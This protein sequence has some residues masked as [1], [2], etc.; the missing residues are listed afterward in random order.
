[1][2]AFE[3][4]CGGHSPE[5]ALRIGLTLD[6]CTFTICDRFDGTPLAMFGCGGEDTDEPY[7]WALASDLLVPRAGRDFI[8]H[9][10]EW[11]KA[12]LKAVGG[13]ACNFVHAENTDATRWLLYCGAEFSPEIVLK[14]NQPFLK[15]TIT[16]KES[17]P[18]VPLL[19]EFTD[20]PDGFI[21]KIESCLVEYAPAECPLV[22]RFT[23][24]MYIRE[25]F[26]PKGTLL[27][28]MKHKTEHPFVISKGEIAVISDNENKVIY[29]APFTGITKPHTRRV[30][31]A[32]ED[33]IW[34]T[35]HVTDKTDVEEI[36]K[37]I[38]EDHSN[39][40][41]EKDHP[42]LNQWKKQLLNLQ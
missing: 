6:L 33:T 40:L 17:V 28:S 32:V 11:I 37:E 8:R 14:N 39:A 36:G 34:T 18:D 31:Y 12:M 42:R 20:N 16:Q 13:K 22:H 9:S 24:G 3:C 19:T 10:P 21:D 2:D 30:L 29:K 5:D 7:I 25:I 41:L 26:I 38:L 1:M 23:K 27:T 35:F 4:H 15:F